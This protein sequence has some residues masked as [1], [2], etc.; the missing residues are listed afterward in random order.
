MEVFSSEPVSLS[1]EEHSLSNLSISLMGGWRY[2]YTWLLRKGVMVPGSYLEI[3]AEFSQVSALT[4]VH[5]FGTFWLIFFFS[6]KFIFSF[7]RQWKRWM[8]VGW[9]G[10]ESTWLQTME[11]GTRRSKWSVQMSARYLLDWHLWSPG[12]LKALPN[13]HPVSFWWAFGFYPAPG[14]SV[15]YL[16]HSCLISCSGCHVI[17]YIVYIKYINVI[18]VENIIQVCVVNSSFLCRHPRILKIP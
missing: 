7:L 14:Y 18:L 5:T 2:W 15:H 6:E 4:D 9:K 16:Q 11:A 12:S 8:R 10:E 13:S 17:L 1:R 3:L